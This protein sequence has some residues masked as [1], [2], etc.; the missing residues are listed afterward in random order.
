M[1]KSV[2]RECEKIIEHVRS[3]TDRADDKRIEQV[4]L[5]LERTNYEPMFLLPVE[6]FLRMSKQ[7]IIKEAER[8]RDMETGEIDAHEFQHRDD[9]DKVRVEQLNMLKRNYSLLSRLRAD[10]PEAWDEVHELYEDD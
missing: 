5:D 6:G 1:E 4:A 3:I 10:E 9:P 8:I 7:E 2:Y